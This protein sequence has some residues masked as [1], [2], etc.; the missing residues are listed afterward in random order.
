MIAGLWGLEEAVQSV[1]TFDIY[2]IISV[3]YGPGKTL[4]LR[5]CFTAAVTCSVR[6]GK[7][8]KP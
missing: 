8:G 5:C 1:S 2:I 4:L 3:S 6:M 7:T